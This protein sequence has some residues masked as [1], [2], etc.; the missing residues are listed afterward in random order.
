MKKFRLND[1]PFIVTN[2]EQIKKIR[3]N[4]E[5]PAKKPE[6]FKYIWDD[7]NWIALQNKN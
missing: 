3:A 4:I 5:K 6:D 7:P 1:P 2:E